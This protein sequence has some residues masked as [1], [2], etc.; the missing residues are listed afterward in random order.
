MMRTIR[1]EH[2]GSPDVL[3]VETVPKLQP[4][5]DEI[6]VRVKAA[7]INSWDWDMVR[8]KPFIVRM[9]GLSKPRYK[10][11]GCDIAGVVEDVGKMVT[12]FK[13]GDAVL[14]DLCECGFGAFA[15]YALAKEDA[16]VKKPEAITFEA[17]ATLPQA[18][19]LALQGLRYRHGV[20]AGQSI[21]INGAGGG[22]GTIAL[23]L[24][25]RMGVQVTCVDAKSK[26]PLLR[27]L[28]ADEVI[29]Y[30]TTDFSKTGIKYDL[31]LDVIANRAPAIARQTLTPSGLYVIEGGTVKT[32]LQTV[33]LGGKR[34]KLMPLK[35]NRGLDELANLVAGGQIKAV[36][37]RVYPLEQ[38]AEAFRF[39]SSGQMQGKIVIQIDRL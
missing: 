20:Q 32:L 13:P 38:T 11:P 24:A 16:L 14:G 6:L 23:Q 3:K 31:V 39:F 15:E 36:I 4:K 25:K 30:T 22:V 28:G 33:L 19:M 21:L 5:P 7:S 10:T 35:P 9:W 1:Y 2:Y 34:V 26:H 37:D 29:D 12:R 18:G 27:S 8:G 17:A